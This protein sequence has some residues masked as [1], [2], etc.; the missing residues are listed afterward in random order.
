VVG[1]PLE[2]GVS[3]SRTYA[4]L[5][6]PTGSTLHDI[7]KWNK[8]ASLELVQKLIVFL[9]QHDGTASPMT[10]IVEFTKNSTAETCGCGNKRNVCLVNFHTVAM[11]SRDE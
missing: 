4:E 10:S 3:S 1:L 5:H 2:I 8:T 6:S 11:Y 9:P 7:K